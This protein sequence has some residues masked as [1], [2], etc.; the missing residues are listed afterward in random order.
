M[1]LK[2]YCLKTSLYKL[3]K[4]FIHSFKLTDIR[5]NPLSNELDKIPSESSNSHC[6]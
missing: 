2:L 6:L 5:K 3:L 4:I 1:Y